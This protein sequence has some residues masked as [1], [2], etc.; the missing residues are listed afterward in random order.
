MPDSQRLIDYN[1][2]Y[3]TEAQVLEAS[4][5]RRPPNPS[6]NRC[7]GRG[8]IS[9]IFRDKRAVHPCTCVQKPTPEHRKG[10]AEDDEKKWELVRKV[11]GLA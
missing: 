11:K 3:L 6:C 10:N 9:I 5:I 2:K 4:S 7:I 8:Y 1:P